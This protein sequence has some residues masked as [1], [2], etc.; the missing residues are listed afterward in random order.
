M[1]ISSYLSRITSEHRN[2]P[3]F[4]ALVSVL[5][6]ASVDGQT[7][8]NS[9]PQIFDV[10]IAVGDQLDIVGLWVGVSRNLSQTI[11]GVSTLDDE[12]YRVLVKLFIAMNAWDGTVPGAYTILD[13]IFAP[14]GYQFQ[15]SDNQ[16]MTMTVTLLNPPANLVLQALFAQGYFALRPAGVGLT[17]VL[18]IPTANTDELHV[19]RWDADKRVRLG[20]YENDESH[21][22]LA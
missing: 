14:E 20:P 7:V 17:I 13:T 22:H 12:S 3:L 4:T 2:Q 9:F 1:D 16:N 19:Q 5:A 15:I 21:T 11:H 18:G 6:Q 8:M 10:D